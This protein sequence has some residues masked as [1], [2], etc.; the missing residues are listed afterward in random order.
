MTAFIDRILGTCVA[1]CTFIGG[2][3]VVAMMVHIC[4]DVVF[5]YTIG[6]PV[7]ATLEMVSYYY[8]SAA[9]LLPLA[10]LERDGSLVFVEVFYDRFGPGSQRF[11]HV[12]AL[13]LGV[14]Y[15][16]MLAYAA[17][18]PALRAYAVG[19]YA[20][21][22]TPVSIWPTRFLPVIGFGLLA[23]V[24]LAKLATLLRGGNVDVDGESTER[25]QP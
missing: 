17:W 10:A 22:L 25:A 21:T 9:V 14:A 5:K 1:I 19:S 20:G 18:S 6:K 12:V 2:I 16:A 24:L 8:M 23:L 4:A 11:F 13:L 3:A 15:C 7:P